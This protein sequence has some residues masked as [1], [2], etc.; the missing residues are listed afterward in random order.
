MGSFKLYGTENSLLE[1]MIFGYERRGGLDERTFRAS[2][3]FG[4]G[5]DYPVAAALDIIAEHI[6]VAAKEIAD[7]RLRTYSGNPRNH[8]YP[9]DAN[10]GNRKPYRDSFDIRALRGTRPGLS[11]GNKAKSAQFVEEGNADQG[12]IIT[13]KGEFLTIPLKKGTGNTVWKRAKRTN[14][15]KFR[16]YD[17]PSFFPGITGNVRVLLYHKPS[18]KRYFVLMREVRSF[19]GYHIMAQAVARGVTSGMLALKTQ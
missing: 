18:S 5:R 7:E 17:G 15:S 11:V 6:M 13:P 12:K 14:N 2:M 1:K 8:G 10:R 19:G 3:R 4:A 16:R 9:F